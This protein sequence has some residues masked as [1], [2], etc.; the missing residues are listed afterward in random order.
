MKWLFM[1]AILV[2]GMAFGSES[3][4]HMVSF[5]NEGF[6]FT[7]SV[8]RMETKD[9]SAF[10]SLTDLKNNFAFNYAYRITN[11]FQL[12]FHFLTSNSDTKYKTRT[13]KESPSEREVTS[14]G[15]FGIYNFKEDFS[16]AFYLGLGVGQT[17]IEEEISHDFLDA[18]GKTP[19]E[20][21]DAILS[22]DLIFGKRF[23]L[24][25]FGI[26]NLVYSP[27]L[28]LFYHSHGKD[29]DDQGIKYGYGFQVQPIKFDFL[30]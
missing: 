14:Y 1:S 13:G 17:L 26:K 4:K 9:K 29:F 12:G 20:I 3:P 8:E 2:S 15:I 21:D 23:S 30:F 22:Y 10:D 11:Q 18:E 16:Q 6:G 27:Q 25:D 24:D 5:T 7:S 28:N 19:M